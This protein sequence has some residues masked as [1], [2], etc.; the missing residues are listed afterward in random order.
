MIMFLDKKVSNF[1]PQ[2][3]MSI[4]FIPQKYDIPLY[5]CFVF[6]GTAIYFVIADWFM[7]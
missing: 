4:K 7:Q 1:P 2:W 6:T 3:A 5:K